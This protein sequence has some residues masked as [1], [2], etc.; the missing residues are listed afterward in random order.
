MQ[1]PFLSDTKAVDEDGHFVD[2]FFSL[3]T[4]LLQNMRQSIGNEGFLV[5]SQTLANM[6]I[7]QDGALEGTMLFVTD[8]INGGT[9]LN[10]NGQLYIKLNDGLFHAI[11]NL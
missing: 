7:I 5:P 4:Q 3:M 9:S 8:A 6:L 2:E 11:P 10:P 1:V